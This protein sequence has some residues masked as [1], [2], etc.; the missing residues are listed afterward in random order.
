MKRRIRRNVTTLMVGLKNGHNRKNLTQKWWTPAGE[1]TKKKTQKTKKKQNRFNSFLAVNGKFRLWGKLFS[2]K[3]VHVNVI[4]NFKNRCTSLWNW[5][6]R[7]HSSSLTFLLTGQLA[8]GGR[9]NLLIHKK[10]TQIHLLRQES[11]K[12]KP[13]RWFAQPE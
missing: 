11:I 4:L 1:R 12:A 5:Y 7:R 2:K 6:Q 10:V 8:E 9:P 3:V 13:R